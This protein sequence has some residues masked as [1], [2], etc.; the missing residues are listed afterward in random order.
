MVHPSS[1]ELSKSIF[2]QM[3]P[4]EE[5]G[6]AT[7]FPVAFVGCEPRYV[8][9]VE[10]EALTLVPGVL[11]TA[12]EAPTAKVFVG[13]TTVVVNVA[14]TVL[15]D[16]IETIQVVPF[17]DVHPVQLVKVDPDADVAVRVAV[18]PLV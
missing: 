17:V 7:I 4:P 12:T 2:H 11:F 14:V 9:L 1:T 10:A 15:L 6:P 18:D 16:V 13:G 8:P 3:Y 5:V